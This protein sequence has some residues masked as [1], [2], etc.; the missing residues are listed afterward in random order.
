[1]NAI[2]DIWIVLN[3]MKS[4][5]C[6]FFQMGSDVLKIVI[7][8]CPN[9][10]TLDYESRI[11]YLDKQ[12]V[13]KL[14]EGKQPAILR[15]IIA[16]YVYRYKHYSDTGDKILNPCDKT[17]DAYGI[18][19]SLLKG[20]PIYAVP[21]SLI[22]KDFIQS[23]I[24]KWL[25]LDTNLN[26]TFDGRY[27][28]TIS[29]ESKN[30]LDNVIKSAKRNTVELKKVGIDGKGTKDN[31][32]ENI[33]EAFDALLAEERKAISDDPYLNSQFIECPFPL[34]RQTDTTGLRNFYSFHVAW[35]LPQVA[36]RTNIFPD[37]HFISSGVSN[38]TG[39]EMEWLKILG[40]ANP[41]S[42]ERMSLK[43]NLKNRKFLFRG[44][45]ED[46]CG[47]C[48]P[49]LHR[50]ETIFSLNDQLMNIEMQCAI[51]NHPFSRLFGIEGVEIFNEKFRMQLNLKG[52]SQH[53]YSKTSCLDLT[54]DV[55]TA[56][57]FAVCTTK[58]G[59][60][61]EVYNPKNPDEPGVIYYY[62]M[63]LPDAFQKYGPG[64]SL[65]PIGKQ[66]IFGRSGQQ[67]GFLIDIPSG[68]DFMDS[69][70]S[71][72]IYFKHDSQVAEEIYEKADRG[73]K[74]FPKNDLL[75]TFWKKLKDC[76]NNEDV[77]SISQKTFEYYYFLEFRDCSRINKP[78]KDMCAVRKD[79]ENQGIYVG[80]YV[81][82]LFP[83]EVI[84]EFMSDMENGW[85]QEFCKDVHF[86]GDEGVF[87]KRSLLE[88][89]KTE[90][91][92]RFIQRYKE[93]NGF[94]KV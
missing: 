68:Y 80:D 4:D 61:Y 69:R 76:W 45:N 17:C 50:K 15:A 28:L 43:P 41:V 32:F 22:G 94:D 75:A 59:D 90:Q 11:L 21:I 79:L 63:Q 8:D 52:L 46:Y 92:R 51:A 25:G 10:S 93:E 34:L 70:F 66:Y 18:I 35:A 53:Y 5:A 89:P 84:S 55:D 85:W 82:P 62:E 44:Q 26:P 60:N 72:A 67:H 48:T 47:T 91:Y 30:A 6:A 54:S 49:N 20:V 86:L 64:Y 38:P 31:P 33:N 13:Y 73:L 14:M 24:K 39:T 23:E 27:M 40:N 83:E 12:E 81:W 57:F 42:Y 71:R 77:H 74:Y 7:D 56:K 16:G 87:M 3:E 9:V 2:Q 65:T 36:H 1:M 78:V 37:N 88:I 29:G 58:D 19:L